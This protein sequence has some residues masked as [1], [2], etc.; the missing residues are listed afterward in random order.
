MAAQDISDQKRHVVT[1]DGLAASGKTALASGLAKRLGWAHLNSGLLYRAAALLA[2]ETK[3]NPTDEGALAALKVGERIALHT[4]GAATAVLIDGR[5]RSQELSA[6]PIGEAAS[7]VA[8]HPGLREQLL[9]AQRGA[10]AGENLI[11]EGRDMGTVVFPRATAKFFVR[12]DLGVRAQRR[13]AQLQ[14]RGMVGEG[15]L[16]EVE[17]E[18]QQRDQ[19]DATR[20]CAPMQAASDAT[21][22]DNSTGSLEE[23]VSHLEALVRAAL[24]PTS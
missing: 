9:A 17:R 11:A 23:N 13:L 7:V 3:V 14:A 19:R 16:A 24:V 4:S 6:Q 10:Y 5:D 18:L 21:E 2:V 1:V 20:A 8:Q 12:A 15:G 22:I